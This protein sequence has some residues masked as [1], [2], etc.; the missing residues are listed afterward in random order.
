[1]AHYTKIQRTCTHTFADCDTGLQLGNPVDV[2]AV[3]AACINTLHGPFMLQCSVAHYIFFGMTCKHVSAGCATGTQ[4][5]DP[6]EMGAASAVLL[7]LHAEAEQT[8]ALTLA[9]GKSSIGH[10]EPAAGMAG[11]LHALQALQSQ[12]VDAI[13]HFRQ[14]IAQ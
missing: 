11:V 10:T 4:L 5:G 9:A 13:V 8:S 7:P 3:L 14:V 1:M 2:G 6:V 12:S